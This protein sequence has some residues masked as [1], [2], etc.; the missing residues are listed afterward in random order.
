MVTQLVA[1]PV[2]LRF[3]DY[4]RFGLWSFTW[5]S[6]GYL[7]LLDFGVSSS[8]GRLLTEPIHKGGEREWNGWFNLSL[9][10]LTIQAALILGLGFIFVGPILHWF[11]IPPGLLVEARQLWLMML[12]LNALTFPL[13]LFQAILMAQNR[14]YWVYLSAAISVWVG[15]LVFYLCLRENCGSLAYGYSAIAQT[16]VSSGLPLAAV[17]RGPNR[18]QIPCAASL[19]ITCANCSD[20]VR[21]CL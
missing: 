11:N 6:L 15:L 4:E 5:Q 20:S 1:I 8:L 18:F 2:A 14:T 12:F 21:R 7:L 17:L 10:V 13:R 16:L 3:L 19:G 9:A